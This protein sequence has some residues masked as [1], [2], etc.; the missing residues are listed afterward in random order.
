MPDSFDIVKT[1]ITALLMHISNNFSIPQETPARPC[2]FRSTKTGPNIILHK[3]GAAL[4][5]TSLFPKRHQ[6]CVSYDAYQT[7]T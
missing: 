6:F 3:I 5:I 7:H 2:S 4:H 1:Q